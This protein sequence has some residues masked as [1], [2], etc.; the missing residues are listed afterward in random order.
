MSTRSL[1]SAP[2][3][4]VLLWGASIAAG[5][6]GLGLAYCFGEPVVAESTVRL[7][8]IVAFA[9]FALSR[10]A[11]LVPLSLAG[12]RLARWALD[13]IILTIA[14]LWWILEPQ[15][16]RHILLA[17]TL[18]I[19]L[20]AGYASLRFGIAALVQGLTIHAIGSGVRRLVVG[21]FVV[22]LL[23]GVVLSLTG[24]WQEV[25]PY[26]QGDPKSGEYLAAHFLNCCFTAAAA[27]SG[28]GLSVL[29]IGLEFSRFGQLVI[30]G[31]MQLG[32][33]VV[34]M[35]GA[36]VGWRFRIGAG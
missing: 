24:G 19:V 22:C 29:D 1:D 31:L 34:L 15:N 23:G 32:G 2:L 7:T 8:F 20:V 10:L 17:V 12:P 11:M 16:E 33:M 25:Y 5:L 35:I 21:A 9:L 26:Q 4:A 28:T 13:Y 18:W 36:A 27:L 3:G 30:I 6:C 14:G